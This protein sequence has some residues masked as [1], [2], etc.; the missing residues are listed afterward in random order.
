MHDSMFGFI[1]ARITYKM[2]TS[3]ATLKQ[4]LNFYLVLWKD[5]LK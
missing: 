4:T 5:I 2:E 1:Y 3:F